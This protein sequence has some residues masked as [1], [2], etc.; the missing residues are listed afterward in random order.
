LEPTWR[1]LEAL[2]KEGKIRHIG[3]SNFG[4]SYLDEACQ[5]GRIASNQIPYNLLWRAVEFDI[6]PR[7]I[8]RQIGLLCYSP[9]AQGLLSGKFLTADEVPEKRARTRLFSSTRK[10]TRHGEPG[11][12]ELT[13]AVL[14]EIREL[15][16]KRGLS[17]GNMALAWLLRQPAVTSVVVGARNATQAADNAAAAE[18]ELDDEFTRLLARLT[19]N[20]K[21]F[22]GP[23]ADPW[24]HVSRM[25]RHQP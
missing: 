9:L 11:C 19:D 21:Q 18:V 2:Q 7:C 13:F 6:Q 17:M 15:A 16:R 10:M 24:E 12:E 1:A 22:I 4:A 8:A 5:I 23:N 14:A 25:E 20:I 3:V